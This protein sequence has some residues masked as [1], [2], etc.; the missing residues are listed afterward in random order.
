MTY[1]SA[2]V[3]RIFT[4]GVHLPRHFPKQ[5]PWKTLGKMRH[6]VPLLAFLLLGPPPRVLADEKPPLLMPLGPAW[7]ANSVNATV[8]RND[9]VTSHADRQYAAYYNGDG[10]V[11]IASR[12]LGQTDWKNTVTSLTGD[13]KDAHNGISI[14][15]DGQG[16]LHVSWD[17]HNHPLRYVR[18]K[19]PGSLEL[20]DRMPMTGRNEKSVS[21]PQFFRMPDGNL[22]FFYRDGGSGRGNLV[23]NRYDAKA[24][25]W[26]Q[27]HPN[28]ISGQG[29]RN[30]YP[31]ACVDGRGMIHLSWV[32]R[33]TPDVATNH[34]LCYAR[35]DDGGKTWTKS[36][37]TAYAVPITAAT[38]EVAS[39]IPQKHELINQTSMCAD[40]DGR[41]IIA[42]YFRPPG[43]NVPQY[44][45]VHH[46]GKAW[47][48]VQ[49]SQRT[50]AFSLSGGGS[51][52][53]PISRPQVF[54]T[55]TG[56]K[57][58]V[59]LIFR[60]AERGSRVSLAHC[61]DLADPKWSVRDLTDLSVGF[62]E[63]SYDRARWQRDG[64]LD[65]YVQTVG[66]GDAETLQDVKP[67]T[68]YVLE[69]EP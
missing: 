50:Q 68:A 48:T 63:P 17:H 8:F 29:K 45:V 5:R 55:S 4:A 6:L 25:E 47:K 60:D 37:G 10:R 15:A 46:D 13:V 39:P 36:D 40:S 43:E 59:G 2:Y 30:A 28:L 67:Q 64:V 20:T 19:S 21:Y 58:S 9:P 42:T 38:A 31:Q 56:G 41:P 32:W 24:R 33:E 61:A 16:F 26:T 23:L 69:M 53:I 34:D 57:T 27:V 1:F 35:S 14:M 65:L 44:F 49:V 51:K 66:Q 7:A 12:T 54:A 22:I 52:A 11:V 18:S 62:W 3:N